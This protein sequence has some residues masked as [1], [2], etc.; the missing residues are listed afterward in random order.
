MDDNAIFRSLSVKNTVTHAESAAVVSAVQRLITLLGEG[1]PPHL[2]EL[3]VSVA[4]KL[5]QDVNE[6]RLAHVNFERVFSGEGPLAQRLA[7]SANVDELLF[8]KH[9]AAKSA[10]VKQLLSRFD[11][12]PTKDYT[13]VEEL[14]RFLQNLFKLCSLAET[15]ITPVLPF[16]QV[17]QNTAKTGF[18]YMPDG[19]DGVAHG[20][21]LAGQLDHSA[22]RAVVVAGT[23]QDPKVTLYHP[24]EDVW[25][26][27]DGNYTLPGLIECLER[28]LERAYWDLEEGHR[29]HDWNAE[30]AALRT[31]ADEVFAKSEILPAGFKNF[32]RLNENQREITVAECGFRVM[33][34]NVRGQWAG[35]SVSILN[36]TGENFGFSTKFEDLELYLKQRLVHTCRREL[37]KLAAA[38]AQG[39]A[40]AQEAAL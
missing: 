27:L 12:Q 11:Y 2:G 18:Y 25:M 23:Y 35:T 9:D 26:P 19:G 38:I 28:E 13:Q 17:T 14:Q 29:D 7:D 30:F 8:G 34:S 15:K 21:V 33:F 32:S 20:V 1:M 6:A 3:F 22:V 5:E 24:Q 40:I 10:R 36:G 16:E 4:A 31:Q 37:N 39:E